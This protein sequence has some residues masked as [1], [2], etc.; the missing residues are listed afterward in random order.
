MTHLR[1]SLTLGEELL[2]Y[3]RM[4]IALKAIRGKALDGPLTASA[5]ELGVTAA[6]ALEDVERLEESADGA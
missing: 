1:V 6:E 2:A 3:A 4:K 5:Y